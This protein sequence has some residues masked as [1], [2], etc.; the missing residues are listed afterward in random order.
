MANKGLKRKLDQGLKVYSAAAAGVLALAPSA[1]AMIHYSGPKNLIVN[2]SN[3]HDIDLNGDA[4]AD[5]RFAYSEWYSSSSSYGKGPYIKGLNGGAHIGAPP[6]YYCTDAIRLASNY[7]IKGTLANNNYIWRTNY[8][9]S[10]NGTYTGKTNNCQGNFNNATGFIGVRFHTAACQESN[11]NYG[12]IR[13]RGDS[14]TSG[15]IIDWAYEDTCNTPIAAGAKGSKVTATAV[16][17]LDQWG[18]IIFTLLLGGL[19]AR[20][21]GKQG[22][23]EG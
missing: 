12:W 9:D 4:T 3:S 6:G 19:A 13:Y 8:W 20:I 15:T 17:T 21:L 7:Q 23:E 14:T 5:F 11:F 16:P 2:P 18:M 1:N 22:K 10:L